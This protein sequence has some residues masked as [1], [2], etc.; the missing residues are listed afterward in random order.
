MITRFS[1]FIEPAATSASVMDTY[2]LPIFPQVDRVPVPEE[3]V[4][5]C[6][7]VGPE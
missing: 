2:E 5:R 4:S 6:L 7:P 1:E 3:A